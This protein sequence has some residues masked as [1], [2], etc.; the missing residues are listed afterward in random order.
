MVT[1][2]EGKSEQSEHSEMAIYASSLPVIIPRRWVASED[3]SQEKLKLSEIIIQQPESASPEANEEE[4]LR[5]PE[6]PELAS[7]DENTV[8]STS[9]F[10]TVRSLTFVSQFMAPHLYSLRTTSVFDDLPRSI[11][12]RP[13]WKD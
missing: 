9:L 5:D 6:P 10:Y 1:D 13:Y 2:V 8:S 12:Y 7:P 4:S 11:S 3:H